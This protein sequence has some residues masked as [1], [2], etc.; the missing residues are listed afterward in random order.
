MQLENIGCVSVKECWHDG[1]PRKSNRLKN[2]NPKAR[3]S[4]QHR[5]AL[6]SLDL[7]KRHP[8]ASSLRDLIRKYQKT[9]TRTQIDAYKTE[10]PAMK[11]ITQ[12]TT[13]CFFGN[14]PHFTHRSKSY[15]Y[16]SGTRRN[17][18]SSLS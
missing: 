11:E 9:Q 12:K 18:I 4:Y 3:R 15:S 13:T 14:H 7:K 2:G 17:H 16:T 1:I 10:R 8:S 6:W 5:F